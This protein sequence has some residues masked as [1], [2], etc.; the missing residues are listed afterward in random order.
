MRGQQNKK[1][2]YIYI[3]IYRHTRTPTL[4]TACAERKEI[5]AQPLHSELKKNN[6]AVNVQYTA[7]S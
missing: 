4:Y 1:K 3:Y 2:I 7:I 5:R 6:K